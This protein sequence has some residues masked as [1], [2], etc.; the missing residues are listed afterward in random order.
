MLHSGVR[1]AHLYVFLRFLFSFI[2]MYFFGQV[3]HR[4][5]HFCIFRTTSP[6]NHQ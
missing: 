4:F 3:G 2:F 1:G 5:C 6:K